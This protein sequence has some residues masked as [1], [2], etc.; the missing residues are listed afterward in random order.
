MARKKKNSF[1][2]FEEYANLTLKQL[3]TL[4]EMLNKVSLQLMFTTDD[5]KSKELE[6][7]KEKIQDKINTVMEEYNEVSENYQNYIND[8]QIASDEWFEKQ[9]QDFNDF[10]NQFL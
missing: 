9:Q 3:D 6:K 7:E 2:C 1:K 8:Q 4:Q 10:M 5:E